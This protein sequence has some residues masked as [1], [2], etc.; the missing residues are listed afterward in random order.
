MMT[1]QRLART[2]TGATPWLRV[3]ALFALM[4]LGA[5]TGQA[6]P[7]SV[8]V[9][10]ACGSLENHY[11]PYD[12]SNATHRTER[13]PIVERFHFNEDVFQLRRG[14]STS[15]I[16][17][18]IAYTLRTFPNH[19]RALDAMS[20]LEARARVKNQPLG[21]YTI[22]CWFDRAI[23]WRPADGMI[24]LVHG[25]HHFRSNRLADA[26]QEMLK[27]VELMPD[28]A[29]AHYNLGLLYVRTG[30]FPAARRHALLAY[31]SGYP[32]PGL[33]N[34][35]IRAGEWQENPPG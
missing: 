9:A 20:R 31:G 24:Y 11:G 33:R 26:E 15:T 29:E 28:S 14:L 25:L 10:M 27:A 34:Q 8:P 13:L 12:Y 5:E 2:S 3:T 23:R 17:D 21:G 1:D 32:L 35:L 6:E 19:H 18:D 22:D 30:N 7:P 4:A 16:A